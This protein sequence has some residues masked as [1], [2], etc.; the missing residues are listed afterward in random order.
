MDI[1][2]CCGSVLVQVVRRVGPWHASLGRGDSVA[3]WVVGVGVR[4]CGIDIGRCA[5]QFASVV[6]GVGD[7]V[8]IGV[9][10]ARAGH[11]GSPP[12]GVIC[13]AVCGDCPVLNL[14]DQIA[15][16]FVGPCGG[17]SVRAG[18]LAHQVAVR[19]AGIAEAAR[20]DGELVHA[21]ILVVAVGVVGY[22]V[23][24]QPLLPAL[25]ARGRVGAR[26]RLAVQ[27]CDGLGDFIQHGVV[28][29]RP[30]PDRVR[31]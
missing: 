18:H 30:R 16:L 13:V 9:G 17:D 20:G 5:R 19:E 28:G 23:D 27:A 4:V 8:G 1:V 10:A 2:L 24:G 3:D 22:I 11:G 21:A 6:V 25:E 31:H 12:D 7:G 14:R 29:E 15:I 26:E